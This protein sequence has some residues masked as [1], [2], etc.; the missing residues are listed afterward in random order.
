M[1]L[2]VRVTNDNSEKFTYVTFANNNVD[3]PMGIKHM[4]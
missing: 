3:K 4:F 1:S 2:V